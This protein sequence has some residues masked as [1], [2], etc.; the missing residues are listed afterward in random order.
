MPRGHSTEACL[1]PPSLFWPAIIPIW[2]GCPSTPKSSRPMSD[3]PRHRQSGPQLPHRPHHREPIRVLW[4]IGG[5]IRDVASN[6]P[7]DTKDMR[8][9][10]GWLI[11]SVMPKRTPRDSITANFSRDAERPM[12][13]RRALILSRNRSQVARRQLSGVTDTPLHPAA[14]QTTPK[15]GGGIIFLPCC[16]GLVQWVLR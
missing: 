2:N 6:G 3:P 10:I 7:P 13:V 8:W 12:K 16:V 5:E 14:Q 4:C 15:M 11:G 1:I 9:Y